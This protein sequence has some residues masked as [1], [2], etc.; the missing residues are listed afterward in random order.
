MPSRPTVDEVL[1]HLRG[2]PETFRR[3]LTDKDMILEL[4]CSYA[5][6]KSRLKRLPPWSIISDITGHGSGVSSAIYELY[7]EYPDPVESTK[8]ESSSSS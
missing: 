8:C 5:T 7:R 1:S 4:M 3:I 2:N 6:W